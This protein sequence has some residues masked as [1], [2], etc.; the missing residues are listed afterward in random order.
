MKRGRQCSADVKAKRCK[1]CALR[2][3]TFFAVKMITVLLH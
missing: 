2:L 3:V 1:S